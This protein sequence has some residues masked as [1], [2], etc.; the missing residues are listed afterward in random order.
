MLKPSGIFRLGPLIWT[1]V[2]VLSLVG[3]VQLAQSRAGTDALGL[4]IGVDAQDPPRGFVDGDGRL[5]GFDIDVAK[6]LC[7][8][9]RARCE[10]IP[11]RR[12]DLI[13]GLMHGE[14]DAV[15]AS[16]PVA[17]REGL[18]PV[19]FTRP[20]Y[21]TQVRL[22]GRSGDFREPDALSSTRVRQVGVW[23]GSG[24]ERYADAQ[25]VGQGRLIGYATQGEALLDLALG[26]LDM[27][28]ADPRSILDYFPDGRLGAGLVFVGEPLSD[29]AGP[30]V[31][32][33]VALPAGAQPLGREL[34]RAVGLLQ[35]NGVL[36]RLLERWFGPEMTG[37]AVPAD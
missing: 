24:M 2:S 36:G 10:L 12:P 21:R 22:V 5:A 14:L 3:P 31:G 6:S 33:G 7:E 27:V 4:R 28:L 17:T 18:S 15:V 23:R 32:R 13:P 8:V 29:S 26:R 35:G 16:L 25:R 37:I 9:L 30:G 1:L 19:D 11:T 34:D 20:Y